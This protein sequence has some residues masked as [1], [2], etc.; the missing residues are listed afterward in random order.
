M[1]IS[2]TGLTIEPDKFKKGNAKPATVKYKGIVSGLDQN[3]VKLKFIVEED[4]PVFLINEDDE[5]VLEISWEED[6]TTGVQDFEHDVHI[7]ITKSAGTLTAVRVDL[8]GTTDKKKKS[9]DIS[10]IFYK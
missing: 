3:P 9:S 5:E 7:K 10:S 4:S 1:D 8:K 6:F 2:I